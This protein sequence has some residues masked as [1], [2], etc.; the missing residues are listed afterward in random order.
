[1]PAQKKK[2]VPNKGLGGAIAKRRQMM[3]EMSGFGP[4]PRKKVAPKKKGKGKK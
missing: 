1:M 2:V 4:T 3:D